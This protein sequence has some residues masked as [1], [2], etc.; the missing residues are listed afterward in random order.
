MKLRLLLVD[1]DSTLR[2][3]LARRLLLAGFEVECVATLSQAREAL[4]ARPPSMVIL[5][6]SQG[7]EGANVPVLLLAEPGASRAGSQKRYLGK[8]FS[9]EQLLARIAEMTGAEVRLP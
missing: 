5:N 8:P 7:L 3:C 4:G 6:S 1:D 2:R 9:V